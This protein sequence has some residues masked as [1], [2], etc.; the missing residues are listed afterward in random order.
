MARTRAGFREGTRITDL[1]GL[2]TLTRY[3]PRRKVEEILRE[4][5]RQSRRQRKLPAHVTVYYVIALCLFMQVS[6]AEV[7]SLLLEGLGRMGWRIGPIPSMGTAGISQARDRVGAE[8]L[9]LLYERTVKPVA[10]EATRGAFYRQWRT[11]SLDGTTLS[12]QDTA[13]NQAGFGRP[14]ASR[15]SSSFPQLR[16][17]ALMENGTRVLFA[18][19]AG[20]LAQP[21][22]ALARPVLSHLK[23]G[24]LCLADRGFF[25]CN[26]WREA[27]AGGAELL[28]RASASLTLPCLKRLA[29]GSYLSRVRSGSKTPCKQQREVQVRVIEYRLEG[30]EDSRASYRLVTTILDPGQA[31]ARELAA[32][33]A[34][35]WE[36]ETALR[37][38]KAGLRQGRIVLRSKKPE[39]VMQELYGLLLAHYAVRAVMHEAALQGDLPADRLSF[40]HAVRVIRR[41][42]PAGGSFPPSPDQPPASG[43]DRGGS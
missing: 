35:R 26:L 8:P 11:V 25:S 34:E 41:K 39:L 28:W 22:G 36:I 27:S 18:A 4:T 23:A 24:M 20:G 37:E 29:D 6:Y 1:I 31:P 33:Y 2:G 40:M 19:Q 32:L 12:L 3:F 15:G 38:I 14:G 16:L 42:L 10:A 7:L 21:E 5:D 9:R 13:E 43:G 30:V 17:V